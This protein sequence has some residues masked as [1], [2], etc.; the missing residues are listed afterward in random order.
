MQTN[1]WLRHAVFF[2]GLL[3]VWML[4][5]VYN[6]QSKDNDWGVPQRALW[7]ALAYALY[8]AGIALILLPLLAERLSWVS[9]ILGNVMWVP[10]ARL[11]FSCYLVHA[12]VYTWYS[13]DK[14]QFDYV[15]KQSLWFDYLS[16]A[17]VSFL[18]SVP[19]HLLF[20]APFINF[21]RL[22]LFPVV[23]R[24]PEK[25]FK[26]D[27]EAEEK[28]HLMKERDSTGCDSHSERTANYVS[29]EN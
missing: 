23:E 11:S 19:F 25:A 6:G 2:A 10:L 5:Y 9:G 24:H 15:S 21:E 17:V 28:S 14:R 1:W 4:M 27:A 8:S 20:E 26:E 3:I 22:L 12:L 7:N 13:A 29:I 18:V 16:I